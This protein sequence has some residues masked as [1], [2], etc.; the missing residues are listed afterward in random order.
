MGRTRNLA[1]SKKQTRKSDIISIIIIAILIIIMSLFLTNNYLLTNKYIT[2]LKKKHVTLDKLNNN[3]IELNNKYK[4]AEAYYEEIENTDTL[5]ENT[6]K[7]VFILASKAEQSILNNK[8]K[9]K[10]AYITFDD[11]PYHLTDK[12]LKTLKEKKVKATFFTIGLDKDICYD[13]NNYSCKETYKKIVDA[14]HTIA[15]HTYSH[16]IRRGLY[17]NANSFI[18]EV[19]KQEKLIKERTGAKTNIIRFPGGSA[20]AYALAGSQEVNNIKNKLKELGYGWVDWTAQDGD[21]GYLADYNL[22]WKNFTSTINEPIEV[23][24][25]HDYNNVT[26]SMLP[27]AINYLEE[28]NYILLPLFYDSVKVNK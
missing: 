6:K 24:L 28:R 10:I 3:Y 11:G 5:I 15:N 7:E 25:F 17:S 13:D 9:Y 19:T 18:N 21:G 26:A 14:G 8:T 23:I 22:G 27:S 16:A 1:K 4:E 2:E 12:V 20:T